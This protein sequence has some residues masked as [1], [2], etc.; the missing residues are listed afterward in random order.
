MSPSV[1]QV[2]ELYPLWQ[3]LKSWKAEA[4]VLA[5]SLAACEM[6]GWGEAAWRM[7]SQST[8]MLFDWRKND[9]SLR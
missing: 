5:I 9:D 1:K 7:P 4:N 6:D 8:L 2:E 3:L